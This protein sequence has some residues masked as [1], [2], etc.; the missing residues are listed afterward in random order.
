MT[1]VL[2]ALTILLP[3]WVLAVTVGDWKMTGQLPFKKTTAQEQPAA[4]PPGNPM[5]NPP[6]V[7]G[8]MGPRNGQ[9]ENRRP[10]G[11]QGP[12]KE[13][14]EAAP[15]PDLVPVLFDDE[16][17]RQPGLAQPPKAA[18]VKQ[19]ETQQE[20]RNPDGP[21]ELLQERA[22][23]GLKR[24]VPEIPVISEG[25]SKM[26][27]GWDKFTLTDATAK[28]LGW[29]YWG[30]EIGVTDLKIGGLLPAILLGLTLISWLTHRPVRARKRASVKLPAGT[31]LAGTAEV[32]TLEPIR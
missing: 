17:P 2:L 20:W 7:P 13:D 5:G 26:P 1:W 15:D 25:W 11:E 30:L 14:K 16:Q 27:D 8:P 32:E 22:K 24:H 3:W 18:P 31:D 28:G 19:G 4:N 23:E 6:G 21:W 9:P 29:A 10:M 12:A